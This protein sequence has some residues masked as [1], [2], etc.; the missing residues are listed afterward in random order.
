MKKGQKLTK[1]Y[2]PEEKED[3]VEESF[4]SDL[5]VR[6]TAE[7]YQIHPSVLFRW[8]ALSNKG[9]LDKT[10]DSN[11]T[12]I[13]AP[14]VKGKPAIKKPKKPVT[15]KPTKKKQQ[16]IA[17]TISVAKFYASADVE[18]LCRMIDSEQDDGASFEVALETII[19]RV[20]WACSYMATLDEE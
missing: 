16:E 20:R 14:I 18:L 1:R 6:K 8:R 15:K 2:T 5:P 17:T 10:G 19:D 12:I 3:I 4:T 7:K 11:I 13:T 9:L